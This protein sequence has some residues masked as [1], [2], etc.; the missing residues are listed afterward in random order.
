MSQRDPYAA[1]RAELRG[2]EPSPAPPGDEKLNPWFAIWIRPR[3]VMRQLMWERSAGMVLLLA[4][5]Q[6]VADTFSQ[7]TFAVSAAEFS[8]AKLLFFA[9]VLGPLGE[10]QRFSAWR[11]LGN[12]CLASLLITAP[13]AVLGILVALFAGSS[14]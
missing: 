4:A 3:A 5:L 13:F 9:L 2:A 1:P 7:S 8:W 14:L 10:V 11:A 12:A 6:G